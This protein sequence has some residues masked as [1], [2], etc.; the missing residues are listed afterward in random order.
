MS[1][2]G[3]VG[4]GPGNGAAQVSLSADGTLVCVPAL[5]I[6]EPAS[7]LA[8]VDRTGRVTYEYAE[9]KVFRDPRF[10]PDGRRIATRVSDG[11]AEQ[12]YVLDPAR[13]TLTRL[14]FDGTYSGM[15]VWS[16]DGEELFHASN[17]ASGALELFRSRLDGTGGVKRLT[18]SGRTRIPT[19]LLP[20]RDL[21]AFSDMN[22]QTNF[23]LAVLS[24]TD[25]K[26]TPFLST[27]AV[28]LLGDFSPDGKWMAY[29]VVE[30]DGRPGV[31]VRS[32]PDG[33]GLRQVSAGIGALPLWTRGGKEL[34]YVDIQ[35]PVSSIMSVDV[36]AEGQGLS[37][38][39]PKKLFELPLA[40]PINATMLDVTD[41]GMR[42]AAILRPPQAGAP[43]PQRTHAAI[44]VNFLE[45]VRR[46]SG[47]R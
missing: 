14:T 45:E 18:S 31:F 16:A 15:P 35:G 8:I 5:A 21:L 44:V 40:T 19:S 13:D 37:L 39:K 33:G 3:G 4:A 24:L 22:P 1:T 17:L 43:A 6:S 36:S 47:P 46:L 9:Q 25:G 28:E 2:G 41:D 34:I 10:S 30:A 42:F 23:D 38:S 7:R 29:M 12:L 11:K 32:F 26:V 27:P 20:E